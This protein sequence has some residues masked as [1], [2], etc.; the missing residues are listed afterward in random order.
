MAS[1]YLKHFQIVS[2]MHLQDGRGST[3]RISFIFC[4]YLKCY[5]FPLGIKFSISDISQPL[6]VAE[7]E[8]VFFLSSVQKRDELYLLSA[9]ILLMVEKGSFAIK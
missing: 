5:A 3:V 7:E 1:S 2:Q 6:F 4:L 8:K 9:I